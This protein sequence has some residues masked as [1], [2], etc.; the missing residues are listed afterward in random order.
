MTPEVLFKLA[1]TIVLPAWILLI[2]VPSHSVTARWVRSGFVSLVLSALYVLA[3]VIHFTFA[4]NGG[5]FNTLAEV[6]LLFT[7]DW[8]LLA[9]WV[10]YLAFDLLI[11][12]FLV[13]HF[14]AKP[15]RR[16]IAMVLTFL[17]GPVGYLFART[18]LRREENRF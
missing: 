8:A 6:R 17:L 7:S 2:F 10:H 9:G 16:T 4:A 1:N 13:D 11:G 14:R 12:A 3:L 15:V 18:V 5:G